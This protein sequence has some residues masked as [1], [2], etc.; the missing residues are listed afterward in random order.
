MSPSLAGG[1]F[2]TEPPEKPQETGFDFIA[3]YLLISCFQ[4]NLFLLY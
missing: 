1:F 2:T 3:L 4:L